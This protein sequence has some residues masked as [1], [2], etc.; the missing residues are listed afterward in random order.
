MLDFKDVINNLQTLIVG[1]NVHQNMAF[2]VHV[3]Y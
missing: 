1:M 3:M 2:D